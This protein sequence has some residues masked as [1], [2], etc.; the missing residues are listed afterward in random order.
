MAAY[1]VFTRERTRNAAQ[2]DQYKL[3]VPASFQQHPATIRAIHGR[4]EVLEGPAIEEII[5]LE[6]PTYDEAKAWYQSPEYQA[7]CE[8]RFQGGDYRCILTEGKS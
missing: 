8:H 3:R 5:I 6:F 2:M 7:A 1:A 4:H